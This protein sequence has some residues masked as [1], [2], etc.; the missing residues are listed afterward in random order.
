MLRCLG[1]RPCLDEWFAYLNADPVKDADYKWVVESFSEVDYPPGW[2][3]YK[4]VGSVII[5]LN[6][7][8]NETTWQH[9]FY[10]Y[11]A[12]LLRVCRESTWEEHIKLRINRILWQYESEAAT[13]LQLQMPLLSPKYIKVFAEILKVDLREEPFLIGTIKLFLSAFS[14]QYH[15]GEL[16]TQEVRWCLNILDSDR[17]RYENKFNFDDPSVALDDDTP[18]LLYCVEDCGAPAE[19]YCLDC[20]DCFCK[21]CYKT[22]HQKGTRFH[23]KP[24]YFI[25]C[26]MCLKQGKKTPAKKHCTYTKEKYCT[27]CYD[28]HAMTLPKFLDLKPLKIDYRRPDKEDSNKPALVD[29]ASSIIIDEDPE[30]KGC[31]SR[32]APPENRLGE[33]WHAFYDLRGVKYYYNFDTEES[34]R[35]PQDDKMAI[36]VAEDTAAKLR[37]EEILGHIAMSKEP[38][39]MKGWVTADGR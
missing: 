21:E 15:Q 17:K 2:V 23:H 35:R 14:T 3:S 19:C 26:E 1:Q 4:G 13:G 22:L 25:D 6:N 8:T 11:F 16:V 18:G 20:G 36:Q 37:R 31:F 9:P 12:E 29:T 34:M 33:S 10:A 30:A 27:E 39:M 7:D 32:P 24:R 28:K 5:Y 38:H